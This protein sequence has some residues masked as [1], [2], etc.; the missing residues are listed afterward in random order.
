M[1]ILVGVLG[2][3][4]SSAALAANWQLV[5]SATDG[6]VVSVD[7]N[8]L[9]K[10]GDSAQIWTQTDYSKVKNIKARLSKELWKFNCSAQTTFTAS[11][12]DYA[13][14]GSVIKS[15]TPIE[16]SYGYA[17]VAPGTVGETVMNLVCG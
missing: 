16:T 3:A 11:W 4:L 8:S 9:R 7:M 2:V 1:K 13:P 12:I 10:S 17:P 14:D 15:H 6:R 5:T